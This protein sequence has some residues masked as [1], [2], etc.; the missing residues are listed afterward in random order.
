MRADCPLTARLN[1]ERPY[2][3]F[4]HSYAAPVSD[5]TVASSD[6]GVDFSAVVAR[7]NV[8][9]VQFHPERS[10]RVGAQILQGFLEL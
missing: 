8:F 2:A 1:G 10:A 9:G 3:Y 5:L 6:H 7:G 4:V